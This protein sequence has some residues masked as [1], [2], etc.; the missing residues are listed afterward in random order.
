LDVGIIAG[1]GWATI[2]ANPAFGAG[3]Y[4]CDAAKV[5]E[6]IAGCMSEK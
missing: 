1:R 2:E 5:L 4:G 3:I 6:T